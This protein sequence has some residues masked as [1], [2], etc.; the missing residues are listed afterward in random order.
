[1]CGLNTKLLFAHVIVHFSCVKLSD[2]AFTCSTCFFTGYSQGGYGGG[3]MRS[4][5]AAAGGG[6]RTAPYGG[7]AAGGFQGR[8][9]GYRGGM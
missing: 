7:G 1:M 5:G 9:G 8:G 4:A 6:Y 2:F 3:P